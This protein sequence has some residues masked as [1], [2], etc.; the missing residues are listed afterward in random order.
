[1]NKQLEIFRNLMFSALCGHLVNTLYKPKEGELFFREGS[2]NVSESFHTTKPGDSD[3]QFDGIIC[4]SQYKVVNGKGKVHFRKTIG[5]EIKTTPHDVERT[6][7]DKYLG[8]MPFFFVA[9]PRELLPCVIFRYKFHPLRKYFG[10]I[11]TD[12]GNIVIMPMEQ[13]FEHNRLYNVLAHCYTSV[14]RY[15]VYNDTEPFQ[16]ARMTQFPEKIDFVS[17][18]GLQVN[19]EYKDYFI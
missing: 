4:L 9:A 18:N 3:I 11:D 17:I 12:S 15:S 5:I 6:S 2:Y 7:I 8:A 10:L 14:H 1:M 19:K 16:K 13:I